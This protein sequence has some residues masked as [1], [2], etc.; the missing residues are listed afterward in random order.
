M[1]YK[2]HKK[3]LKAMR[4]TEEKIVNTVHKKRD[5]RIIAQAVGRRLPTA[6]AQVQ[7]QVK[8]CGICGGQSGF[9]FSRQFSFYRLLPTHH[10][11]SGAGTIGQLVAD[12]PVDSVSPHPKKLN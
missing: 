2:Y 3:N 12:V 6:A 10:L 8:S 5:G 11:S 4:K 9:G 7:A 1:Y